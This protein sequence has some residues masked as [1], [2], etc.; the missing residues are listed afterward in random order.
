MKIDIDPD[1]AEYVRYY[2]NANGISFKKAANALMEKGV[3]VDKP[4]KDG[5]NAPFE[6]KHGW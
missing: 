4:K 1:L 5:Y 2:A 3:E 6:A